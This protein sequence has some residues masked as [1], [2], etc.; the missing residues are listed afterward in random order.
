MKSDEEILREE[1]RALREVILK[2]YQWGVAFIAT[3][4]TAIFFIRREVLTGLIESGSLPKGALLPLWRYFFGT[5]VVF[6]I[7]IFFT[8]LSISVG[9]RLRWYQK[10][11]SELRDCAQTTGK[12]I[13]GVQEPPQNKARY[14]LRWIVIALYFL[15]PCLDI[16][17]RFLFR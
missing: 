16:L 17:G 2:L 14:L 12:I 9:N 10:Q 13:S 6:L 1:I 4:Q 15:F 5:A 11:L 7:A 8:M 3:L